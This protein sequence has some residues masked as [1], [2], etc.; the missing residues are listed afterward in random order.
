[1]SRTNLLL[2]LVVGVLG[3]VVVFVEKPWSGRPEGYVDRKPLFEDFDAARVARLE[4]ARGE[5]TLAIAKVDGKWTLPDLGGYLANE[6]QVS[7][8]ISAVQQWKVDARVGTAKMSDKYMVDDKTGTRVVLK[9]EGGKVLADLFTGRVGGFDAKEAQ[10]QGGKV[11]TETFGIYVRRADAQDVY[12]MKGLFLGTFSPDTSSFM[13]RAFVSFDVAKASQFLA[14]CGDRR[15]VVTRRDGK[16]IM[17]GLERPA[18]DEEVKRL[19]EGMSRLS[20]VSL[21]GTYEAGKYGL[22]PPACVV[23][24]TMED[25]TLHI[26]EVGA[27]KEGKG[28]YARKKDDPFVVVISKWEVECYRK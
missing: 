21:E 16:W 26:L 2:L 28:Y 24:V 1:V 20:A 11:D 10:R 3:A 18:D 14:S 6:G 5:D 19:V 13:D 7:Q 17:E 27:E 8:V 22:E 4:L 15:L 25:G 23:Q 12:F 9:D